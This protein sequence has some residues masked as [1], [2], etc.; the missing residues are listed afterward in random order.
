VSEPVDPDAAAVDHADDADDVARVG[1]PLRLAVL[2]TGVEALALAGSAV[3]LAMYRYSGH[4]PFDI[5][6]MWAVVAMAAI[7]A[8]GLGL[9]VRGLARARRWARSPAVLTQLIGLP[10]GIN[11]IGHGG[12]LVGILLTLFTVVG[13]F[14]LFAPS[15]SHRLRLP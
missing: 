2:A 7:G 12:E 3:G 6:D 15:T 4:R 8:I 11:A 14:G 13:L 1:V 5:G 9:V 10:I